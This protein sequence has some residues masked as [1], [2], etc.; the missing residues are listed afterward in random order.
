MP[1][2]KLYWI[3]TVKTPWRGKLAMAARP[4][5]GDWL[6]DEMA[7]WR[8]RG[9]DTVVSFLTQEEEQ[10]LDVSAERAEAQ[11][12]GLTFLSFPIPDR[13][14]PASW[15]EFS[16]LLAVLDAELTVGKNVVM[17]CRQ[18]IGRTG[19]V[20]AC[21]LALT[22][23]NSETAMERLSDARGVTVPE[24]DKQRR[25]IEEYTASFAVSR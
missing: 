21:L 17:H 22:G 10:D 18:G 16:R 4:R 1:G 19:L 11:A 12:H 7:D 8:G 13:E 14:V 5:G 9:L 2:T 15:E 6:E 24:T 20:A 25:W 3:D 23:I